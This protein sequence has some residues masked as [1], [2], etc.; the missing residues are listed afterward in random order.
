MEEARNR[1]IERFEFTNNTFHLLLIALLLVTIIAILY[2]LFGFSKFNKNE[3]MGLPI[4]C[5]FAV[6][7]FLLFSFLTH[8]MRKDNEYLKCSEP[9]YIEG[10]L[11]GFADEWVDETG[12]SS[13]K[14][15]PI[16]RINGTDEEITLNITNSEEKMKIGETYEILYLPNTKIAEIIEK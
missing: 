6:A 5:I 9:I 2:T 15:S 14:Y 16:I 8:P 11:I 13:R 4:M 1:L 3:K 12:I 10:E 7:I